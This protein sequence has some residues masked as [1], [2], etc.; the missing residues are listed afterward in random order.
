MIA[1][2][3]REIPRLLHCVIDQNR[4]IRMLCNQDVMRQIISH[5]AK[6]LTFALNLL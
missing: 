4:D 2:G 6:I 5:L 1:V 3:L